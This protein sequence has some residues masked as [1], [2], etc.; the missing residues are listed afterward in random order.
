MPWKYGDPIKGAPLDQNWLGG[1]FNGLASYL[2]EQIEGTAP[3]F[4]Y[5]GAVDAY[6]GDNGL[7]M[8]DGTP[9]VLKGANGNGMYFTTAGEVLD[10]GI[11]F[12][13]VQSGG[14]IF[15]AI[16]ELSP[17]IAAI[18]GPMFM[19]TGLGGTL[20]E[21]PGSVGSKVAVNAVTQFITTGEIFPTG[22]A[23][24]AAGSALPGTVNEFPGALDS[25]FVS[26]TVLDPN[27]DIFSDI[28]GSVVGS[29]GTSDIV[30]QP[31]I[32]PYEPTDDQFGT[33]LINV[34]APAVNEFPGALDNEFVSG[35]VTGAVNE[36]PGATANEFVSGL[37]T[38]AST[39]G[40]TTNGLLDWAKQNKELAT[41]IV[42]AGGGLLK[43]IG[44]RAALL[45]NTENQIEWQK[46]L[47]TERAKQEIAQLEEKR[48]LTQSG[49]YWSAPFNY[50]APTGPLRRP[51]GSLVYAP[52]GGLIGRRQP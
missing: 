33:G 31:T 44:D 50:K 15:D 1:G 5:A 18:A 29:P 38:D 51:D 49:S 21:A 9:M 10:T 41:G 34:G 47:I 16:K 39:G 14:S 7:L 8:K 20:H 11:P 36:F 17:M 37:N 28:T 12:N 23:I 40:D 42:M 19:S 27:P 22:L 4:E 6:F 2:K 45:E 46:E 43:G 52:G 32:S 30:G 24:S 3:G 35:S 13:D 48:K 26:G 25:E